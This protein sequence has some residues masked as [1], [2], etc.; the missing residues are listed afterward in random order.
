MCNGSRRGKG[1]IGA[2]EEEAGQA[3][4]QVEKGPKSDPKKP[5]EVRHRVSWQFSSSEDGSGTKNVT[6]KGLMESEEMVLEISLDDLISLV[7]EEEHDGDHAGGW[8]R[9]EKVGDR[10]STGERTRIST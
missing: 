7:S 8:S 6:E 2:E 5:R 10:V 4:V 9:R 3:T 1:E